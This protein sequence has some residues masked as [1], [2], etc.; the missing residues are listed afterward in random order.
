MDKTAGNANSTD[1]DEFFERNLEAFRE[2]KPQ[3]YEALAAITEPHSQLVFD[4]DGDPDIEFRGTRLY[5]TG[6]RKF[7]EKQ[8]AEFWK[9]PFR[10]RFVPPQNSTLDDVAGEFNFRMLR[11]AVDEGTEFLTVASSP[12]TFF[13]ISYGIG[14]GFHLEPLAGFSNCKTLI[15]I[16]P[17]IEFLYHSLFVFDWAALIERLGKEDRYL[18]I[19]IESQYKKISHDMRNYVRGTGPSF[20]DSTPV[21]NHYR[22]SVMDM[23]QQEFQRDANL[24]LSGLGFIEDEMLMIENSFKNLKDYE[25]HIYMRGNKTRTLPAFIVGC[26]PSID[27]CI[28]VIRDNQDKAIIISCG[29]ALGVLLAAGIVPDF[30]MEMENVDLVYDL[31]SDKAERYDLSNLCLVASTTVDPR[32][33]PIFERKVLYFRQ[34][35]SS[36]EVFAQGP[37]SGL[38]EV[39]PTVANSGLSF[40]QEIGCREFY[41]FGMDLGA[42]HSEQHHSEV[43]DYRPGGKAGNTNEWDRLH[44]GNFGGMVHTHGIF[45]WARAAV[46]QCLRRYKRGRTYY[47]C[48]DGI[49]MD[50]AVPKVPRAV[51][52]RGGVDKQDEIGN[53]LNE[54]PKYSRD[55]FEDSWFAVD[56]VA[57]VE[58]L[59]DTLIEHCDFVD[60]NYRARFMAKVARTLIPKD[61]N[62]GAEIFLIRG[63]ILMIMIS[64]FYYL[65]RVSD[66]EKVPV[67]EQ[68]IRE[69]MKTIFEKI[70][71]ETV[72]FLKSLDPN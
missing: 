42:A 56:R 32:V 41:F 17:N 8:V 36:W 29:T 5:G 63:S 72:A 20:F 40:A 27:Q 11:H 65:S 18:F 7:A 51:S 30:Q 61:G 10:L 45:I 34:S 69:E 46:E 26:G 43:S 55:R 28:D 64:A 9:V 31:L 19:N 59:C 38:H 54:F 4:D 2:S 33:P 23:V 15:L 70:K 71:K 47:N 50:G 25:S 67:M 12:E 13:L 39:G 48:S 57:A 44:A 14:L 53:I 49:T 37:L 1:R 6:A 60:E 21:F 3:I 24:Y 62:A 68:I 16:E 22:N 66:P 58:E 35:L 52:L